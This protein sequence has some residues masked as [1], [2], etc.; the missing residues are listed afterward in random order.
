MS[1]S[2]T[3]PIPQDSESPSNQNELNDNNVSVEQ[4][5]KPRKFFKSRNA[6]PPP[7][8]MV[9]AQ[10]F[11]QM[12]S[13]AMHSSHQIRQP[14]ALLNDHLSTSG[15]DAEPA[16]SN[17]KKRG[18]TSPVKKEKPPKLE[19]SKKEKPMKVVKAKEPPRTPKQSDVES[20]KR[21]EKTQVEP[22]RSS[23]RSRAKAVNYNEDAGEDEFQT[24]IERRIVPKHATAT[25]E[26]EAA[27]S[28]N[29]SPVHTENPP[30]S[31][32]QVSSIHPPIVLRISK[33]SRILMISYYT[34]T[35]N[36][37]FFPYFY[38]CLDF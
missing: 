35:D 10:H 15:D 1:L 12:S 7:T 4:V 27:Q 16:A 21:R 37:Y 20:L 14:A 26:A 38:A 31:S 8:P 32:Q 24:R 3:S 33:V 23:G 30:S 28:L 6:A 13:Q 18:K 9:S 22:T 2:S 5:P 25:S 36:Q 17:R 19:K 11:I 29:I 34:Y